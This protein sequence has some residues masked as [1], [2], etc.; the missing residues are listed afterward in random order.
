M[1]RNYASSFGEELAPRPT[2]QAV[3][4]NLVGCLRLHIQYIRSYPPYWRP[5]LHPQPEDAPCRGDRNP[6]PTEKKNCELHEISNIIGNFPHST[7]AIARLA[8][9]NI[10][11]SLKCL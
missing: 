8:P 5:F 1:F 6:L 11:F 10:Q 9:R 7:M 3:W 4:P 2:P